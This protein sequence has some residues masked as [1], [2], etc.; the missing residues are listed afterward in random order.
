MP[1]KG[2]NDCVLLLLDMPVPKVDVNCKCDRIR[3]HVFICEYQKHNRSI[4]EY[5]PFATYL[6]KL[7]FIHMH[8]LKDTLDSD[9]QSSRRPRSACVI[10]CNRY[11]VISDVSTLNSEARYELALYKRFEPLSRQWIR[12]SFRTYLLFLS[13]RYYFPGQKSCPGQEQ[14]FR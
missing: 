3:Y 5:M 14:W 9:V 12:A 4:I 10:C 7:T 2:Q 13:R 1:F 6:G 8:V 11:L